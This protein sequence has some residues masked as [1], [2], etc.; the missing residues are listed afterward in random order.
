MFF[1]EDLYNKLK[2]IIDGKSCG[3]EAREDKD[4]REVVVICGSQYQ[5]LSMSVKPLWITFDI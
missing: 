1:C 4:E 5:V 2:K 3:S